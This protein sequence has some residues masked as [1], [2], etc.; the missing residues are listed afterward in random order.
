M[1][2]V[3]LNNAKIGEGSII[4]AGT[5][6]PEGTVIEPFSLWMGVPGKF[7]KKIDNEESQKT[8]LMYGQNYL[9]YKAQYLKE[10][11]GK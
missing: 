3:V 5:V 7:K 11:A 9:D 4:A 2:S 10:L 6:I 8:I 1:G